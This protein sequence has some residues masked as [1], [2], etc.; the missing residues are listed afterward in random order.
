MAAV[1]TLLTVLGIAWLLWLDH[2]ESRVS[3]ALWVPFLWLLIAS[4]RPISSWGSSPVSRSESY[5]E[6]SPLDRALLMLLIAVGLYILSKRGRQAKAIIGANLPIVLFLFYCLITILWAE[7]PFVA[8]KRW[9]RGVADVVMVLVILTDPSGVGAVQWIFSRIGYVLVPMSILFIRFYPEFGRMYSRGGA[10]MWTGV[11]TDKNALGA[12]CMIVGT[13]VL[14]RWINTYSTPRGRDRTRRL[15]AM[16]AVLL[17]I[18][19]LVSV[20]DSKTALMCFLLAIIVVTFRWL[21]RKPAVTFLFVTSSI[22]AC[23]AVLILGIGGGALEAIGRDASLTGRTDVWEV[24]L[25]FVENPWFGAGYENFWI[26]ERLEHLTDWGGNTAHNGYL[27]IYVNLGWIGLILLG[28][29]I[30]TGYRNMASAV[31]SDPNVGRLRL[32]FFVICLI[33]NFSEAAFKMMSPVWLMFLW[34]TMAVPKLQSSVNVPS[35][36]PAP[37]V[38][39]NERWRTIH[40]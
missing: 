20:V 27:E 5:M 1:A 24:V 18:L 39:R 29:V 7:F 4:S 16:S 25:S 23:Y 3:K 35:R 2:S 10:P 11:C 31:R 38:Q 19:Y 13:V 14:W 37:A 8:F 6:G 40:V 17:M 26:G 34:A 15:I 22:A 9:I 36:V 33:Y 32:A 28:T 30:L 12:L 21:I